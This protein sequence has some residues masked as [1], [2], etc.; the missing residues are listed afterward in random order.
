MR[1]LRRTIGLF[2]S[3]WTCLVFQA[4]LVLYGMKNKDTAKR[5]DLQCSGGFGCLKLCLYGIKVLA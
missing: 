1:S 2:G 5:K 4:F 3:Y